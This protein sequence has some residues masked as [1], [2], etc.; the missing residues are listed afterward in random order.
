M[1]MYN[2][3]MNL[4]NTKDCIGGIVGYANDFVT[5]SYCGFSGSVTG[6]KRRFRR[7]H[8]GLCE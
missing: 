8:L 4:P 1:C 5:V 7:R 3:N 6:M 2:G